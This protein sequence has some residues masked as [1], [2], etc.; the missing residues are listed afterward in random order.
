MS[1]FDVHFTAEHIKCKGFFKKFTHNEEKDLINFN[2]LFSCLV[3]YWKDNGEAVSAIIKVIGAKFV[4]F[5]VSF[6][7]YF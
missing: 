7:I 2:V 4:I 3:T 1:F 6:F 5:K